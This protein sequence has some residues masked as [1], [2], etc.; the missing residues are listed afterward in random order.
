MPSFNEILE[1]QKPRIG[2]PCSTGLWRDTLEPGD[3]D[4]FDAAL[5][6]PDITSADIFRTMKTMGFAGGDSAF[7]R[8][9]IGGCKCS[10]TN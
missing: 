3:R 9:R 5:A 6:N 4:Q 10:T 1:A 2:Q 7:K 8:H